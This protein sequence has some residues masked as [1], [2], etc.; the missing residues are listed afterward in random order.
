MIND[1]RMWFVCASVRV[2]KH[3]YLAV[4]GAHKNRSDIKET[5]QENSLFA[6]GLPPL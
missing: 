1:L 6:L 3:V 4:V 2:G 5:K